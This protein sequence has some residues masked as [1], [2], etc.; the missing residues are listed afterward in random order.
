MNVYC[1][2]AG[3]L[4]FLIGVIASSAD[5][6]PFWV[7][8]WMGYP[9]GFGWIV[10]KMN[11]IDI[12]S[13]APMQ[14]TKYGDRYVATGGNVFFLI[15][16]IG[17]GFVG[18]VCMPVYTVLYLVRIGQYFYKRVSFHFV[19]WPALIAYIFMYLVPFWIIPTA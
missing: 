10:G 16:I 8:F 4:S 3:V 7:Y 17:G 11:G 13:I 1:I 14:Y 15:P 9:W 6:N 2:V 18:M 12:S 5:L 19:F